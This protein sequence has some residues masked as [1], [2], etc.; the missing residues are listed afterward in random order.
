MTWKIGFAGKLRPFLAATV[1]L[2][3]TQS[4]VKRGEEKIN[5]GCGLGGTVVQNLRYRLP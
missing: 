3:S 5:A 2:I 4:L 1:S